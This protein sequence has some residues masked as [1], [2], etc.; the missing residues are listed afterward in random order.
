MK[1]LKKCPKCGSKKVNIIEGVSFN[2]KKCGYVNVQKLRVIK[3][4]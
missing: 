4:N 1:Y 3:E 2:C